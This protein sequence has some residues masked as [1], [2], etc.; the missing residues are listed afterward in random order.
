MP[1]LI[2]YSYFSLFLL[3]LCSIPRLLLIFISFTGKQCI[4]T[5]TTPKGLSRCY[6]TQPEFERKSDA[7]A[8]VAAIAIDMDAVDFVL[9]GDQDSTNPQ[10]VPLASLDGH[11]ELPRER[12]EKLRT[13][14][15]GQQDIIEIERNCI[16]WRAA[17]VKPQW[18][19]FNKP[20]SDC[21]S[22]LATIVF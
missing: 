10:N 13:N 3:S 8:R 14:V 17:R 12:K 11:L 15:S 5:I 7:K 2:F 9:H 20:K 18:I 21:E 6:T 22:S 4:L 19:D 16:E 1:R